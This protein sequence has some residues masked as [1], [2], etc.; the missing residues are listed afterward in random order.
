MKKKPANLR[1]HCRRP[2]ME[3]LE[4]RQLLSASPFQ[5][6]AGQLTVTGTNKSDHISV[7]VKGK[8]LTAKMDSKTKTF[9]AASVQSV[10]VDSLAGNDT[11][12]IAP[13]V[14]APATVTGGAGN[15]TFTAGGGTDVLVGGSGDNILKGGPGDTDFVPSTG[16]DA[17][18]NFHAGDAGEDASNGQPGRAGQG[19]QYFGSV[20][21]VD[22]TA[23]MITISTFAQASA[24]KN[25]T[26]NV[27]SSTT[28]TVDGQPSTLAALG[29]LT[30]GAHVS[31]QVSSTDATTAASIAAVGPHVEGPVVSVD[32]T[33]NTIT[34][35]GIAG[36]ANETYTVSPT[37][38]ITSA[39]AAS[40]LSAITAGTNV[41]IWLS[42]IDGTTAVAIDAGAV[43]APAGGNGGVPGGTGA[44]GQGGA[45]IG[46]VLSVD[47][48]AG[49]IT[50]SVL[51]P[52]GTTQQTFS[53]TSSTAITVDGT[54]AALSN[55]GSLSTNAR[56]IVQ[57]AAGSTTATAISAVGPNVQGPVASVD[58]T[59]GTITLAGPNGAASQTFT[60]GATVAITLD[61]SASTLS[62]IVA[63]DNADLRLS[64]TDGTTVIAIDASDASSPANPGNG[65]GQNGG[66]GGGVSGAPA[67]LSVAIGA[68]ASVDTT[69]DT[70]TLS[71]LSPAG[72][73]QQETFTVTSSTTITVD[74]TSASLSALSGLTSSAQV[75]V[76]PSTTSATTAASIAAVGPLVQGPV[77]SVDTT[78]GTVTLGGPNGQAG[79]AYAVGASA[80]VT[81]DGS[82][83]TLAGVAAGD[84]A[85]IQ[86]S[87]VDGSTVVSVNVETNVGAGGPS[88]GTGT[89]TG[90]TGTTT[91]PSGTTTPPSGTTTPPSG[92]TTTPPSGTTTP[93]SGT[94][95][96][97][98]G[99]TTPP[100][101]TT[102]PPGGTGDP[103]SGTGA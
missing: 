23:D 100:S 54:T 14:T 68:V 70:I 30:A 55:L 82:A 47:A 37:A 11:V 84:G 101:G 50:L 57:A 63:G 65:T 27:P 81:I 74:G 58:S 13:T 40:T 77:A 95:T 49:T 72:T 78:A 87:A 103:S 71:V 90:G 3:T 38:A 99:T 66:T 75:I 9:T 20:V 59:D 69:G 85:Q 12:T 76:Q 6:D 8:H 33:D 15:D 48:S 34:L 98:S 56:V 29:S 42:A 61:G 73:T 10:V 64:A 91:P 22:T 25:K 41:Q 26:F 52:S 31:L 86:L 7:N 102:P 1:P 62:A 53:V 21:S 35:A 2:L 16:T 51:A 80:K 5:L 88:G 96:P 18:F 36:A 79:Q 89:S 39:G 93:P 46:S 32:A 92:G 44:P 24:V 19:G 17:V 4:A 43:G 28:I 45:A 67:P 83:G 60:I 94:T 97:P